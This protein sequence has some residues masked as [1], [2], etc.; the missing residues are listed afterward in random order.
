MFGLAIE[1]LR[2]GSSAAKKR[3][4]HEHAWLPMTRPG[5]RQ[6]FR[7]CHEC[8][9]WEFLHPVSAGSGEWCR[10]ADPHTDDWGSWDR[11]VCDSVLA[12]GSCV[13][14]WRAQVSTYRTDAGIE[15]WLTG[16]TA[17]L[18]AG[19]KRPK[20]APG[21]SWATLIIPLGTLVMSAVAWVLAGANPLLWLL[22]LLLVALLGANIAAICRT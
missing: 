22:M 12:R 15:R 6:H 1:L 8:G 11:L 3:R 9:R 10:W 13:D 2:G 16:V 14:I 21:P 17:E 18:R 19:Y 20:P 4:D 7:R 5:T